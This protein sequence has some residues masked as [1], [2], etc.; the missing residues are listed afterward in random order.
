VSLP[1]PPDNRAPLTPDQA[2]ALVL[3]K[4]PGSSVKDTID[5]C[6]ICGEPYPARRTH[7]EWSIWNELHACRPTPRDRRRRPR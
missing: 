4:F 7:L 2:I 1:Q 6:P 3:E 5:S